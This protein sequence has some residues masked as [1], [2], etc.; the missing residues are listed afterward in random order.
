MCLTLSESRSAM[1]TT[2]TRLA[3]A[4]SMS[5]ATVTERFTRLDVGHMTLSIAITIRRRTARSPLRFCLVLTDDRPI[6]RALREPR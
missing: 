3:L 4:C 5:L 6:G 2:P 1:N